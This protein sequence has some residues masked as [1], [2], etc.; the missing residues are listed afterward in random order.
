MRV[1]HLSHKSIFP[2]MD[3]GCKAMKQLMHCLLEG[4]YVIDH[5]CLGTQKH[6]YRKENYPEEWRQRIT[7]SGHNI[8][9]RL[10]I[11]QGIKHLVSRKS[12]NISRFNNKVVHEKLNQH[13]LANQYST[14]LLESIFLAPY[15]PTI[16]KASSAKI[17]LRTHNVEHHLW[18]QR[19]SLEKNPIKKWLLTRLASDLKKEEIAALSSVDELFAISEE[20]ARE[21]KQLGIATTITVVPVAFDQQK[22]R[23]DYSNKHLFF[24]GAMN[25]RPNQEALAQLINTIFPA[26][27]STI[28]DIT[29]KIA[30]SFSVQKKEVNGI[31]HLGFVADLALFMQ[32][33]GILV[34]PIL[35]G[36]GVRIK[37]LEAMAL[38][39]PILTT[40]VGLQGIPAHSGVYSVETPH[41]FKEALS[42]IISSETLRREMGTKAY[43]FIQENYTTSSIFTIIRASIV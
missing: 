2:V 15:I 11:F 14:V 27:K 12:Y 7:I 33:S 25:W 38:G 10:S 9:T 28:S 4:N 35:S 6:P 42:I 3:G 22:N 1:L 43:Q 34:L 21:F 17:I 41:D 32:T 39:V 40:R 13:L 18:E 16:R 23:V 31:E 19:A 37:I 26:I 5:F 8:T 24:V 20:D 29:L 30:G 36:S